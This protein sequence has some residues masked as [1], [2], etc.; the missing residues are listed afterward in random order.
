MCEI[1]GRIRIEMRQIRHVVEDLS[2]AVPNMH[3]T[4]RV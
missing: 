2:N 4:A 3:H 1:K